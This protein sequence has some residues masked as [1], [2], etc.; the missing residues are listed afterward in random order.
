M[1][2]NFLLLTIACAILLAFFGCAKDEQDTTGSIAGVITDAKTA[3]TLSGA[4]VT[5]SPSGKSFTTGADGR[6]EFHDIAIGN[7]I[8]QATKAG[9]NE[10]QKSVEVLAGKVSTLDMPLHPSTPKL[11]VST[12]ILDFGSSSTSQTLEIRNTGQAELTW[13]VKENIPWL[14]CSLI[15]GT[16]SAGETIGIS[17]TID[18][19]GLPYGSHEETI[20]ITSNGGSQTIKVKMIV[21]EELPDEVVLTTKE[22]SNITHNE[23]VG[24]GIITTLRGYT[25]KERGVCW[26]TQSTPTLS[27][28][29]QTSSEQA[30]DFTVKMTG[31]SENTTYHVRAYVKTTTGDV[32]YGEDKTFQ[33]PYEI[34]LATLSSVSVTDVTSNSATFAASITDNGHGKLKDAGFV[35][36]TTP[37]PTTNKRSC[38]TNNSLQVTASDLQPETTYYVRAY[39]ENEKGTS[40]S[41]QKEFTTT[42]TTSAPKVETGDV[43]NVKQKE[44]TV[45]GNITDLGATTGITEYGHVWSTQ[46]NPTVNDQKTN[47]GTKSQKGTFTST[48]TDLKPGTLYYIRAYAR[49]QNGVGYGNE[50][51][52]ITLPGEVLLATKAVSGIAYNEATCGGNITELQGHTITERGLCWNT[53]GSPTVSGSHQVSSEKTN[54]FTVTMTGLSENTAYF[55]RAYVKTATGDIFYGGNVTF[56]TPY[57]VKLATLSAVTATGVTSK[58]ATFA[59]TVTSDGHGTITDAGFVYSTTHNPTVSTNKL[60]CGTNTT[61]KTTISTLQPETTYYVRAYATNEKG[62]AYGAETTVITQSSGSNADVDRTDWPKDK[63]WN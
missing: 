46:S 23:A 13:Q 54:D 44:V 33:T 25:I 4:T 60:S 62:T 28:S 55:V 34:K 52:A 50:V 1:K 41:E 5:L 32:F 18:R 30:D 38:G 40:Y 35:Y 48:L 56:R 36:A 11:A 19:M 45:A 47:L 63:N 43:T 49:N 22:I 51:Q 24:G 21:Q 14:E 31:L 6:Y 58:S 3:K 12:Q 15:N 16:T 17:V 37:N 2:R 53:Q 26:N 39:A 59:A 10:N 27:N 29:H 42:R 61:L 57:E 7:Y 20:G 8:V 9:Y